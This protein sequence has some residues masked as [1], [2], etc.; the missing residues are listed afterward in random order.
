MNVETRELIKVDSLLL[1]EKEDCPMSLACHPNR[2]LL[3]TGINSMATIIEGGGPN[4]NCRIFHTDDG[5]L[6]IDTTFSTSTSKNT[7]EYQVSF[8]IF[9]L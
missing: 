4:Q 1:S 3:A 8:F 2:P 7:E 5:K 6:E 9:P